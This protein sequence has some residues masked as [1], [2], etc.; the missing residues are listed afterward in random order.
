MCKKWFIGALLLCGTGLF[1]Q[2]AISGYVNLN[3]T[4]TWEQKVYLTKWNLADIQNLKYPKQ[5]VWT[6]IKEDGYFS[7]K[8]EHI[9]DKNTIYRLHINR[10]Q[11]IIND[12]IVNKRHFI[13][14]NS[15]SIRFKKGIGLFSDYENSNL[16]DAEWRKLSAFE[17]RL[18]KIR[19]EDSLSS[20][21]TVQMPLYAKDSLQILMVKLI[22]IKQLE[23]KKLLDQDIAKNPSYYLALLEELKASDLDR[24]EYLFLEKKLA[25]LTNKMVEQKYQWSKTIILILAMVIVGLL[26]SVI[27][28]KRKR[29]HIPVDLSK[30][31][32]NIQGLILEGKSNKEI[33]NELFISISTVKTHITNIY[34]KLKVSNREELLQRTQ[35]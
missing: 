33:A 35:N 8:R 21:Y 32:Q 17:G 11:R 5:V 10:I 27:R 4:G 29:N 20:A 23:Y 12:T 2:N 24:S 14:S 7:F 31:E 15:D 19:N 6:S 22:G 30:Q 18:N 28:L 16:A 26:F 1:A 13:L 3:D 9:A 25:Y 34:G